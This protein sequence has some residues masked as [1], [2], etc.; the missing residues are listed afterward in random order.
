[1]LECLGHTLLVTK[2]NS[3]LFLE[4]PSPFLDRLNNP[5][6]H[7]HPTTKAKRFLSP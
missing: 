1:M 7:Y 6:E 4:Y 2:R 3:H 5:N